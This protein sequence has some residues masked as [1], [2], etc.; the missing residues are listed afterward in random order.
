MI[1][2]WGVGK[3]LKKKKLFW[4]NEGSI[5]AFDWKNWGKPRGTS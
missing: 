4:Y 5:S 2:D 1:D 3:D